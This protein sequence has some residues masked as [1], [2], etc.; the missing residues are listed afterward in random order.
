MTL[1]PRLTLTGPV[2]A[3]FLACLLAHTPANAESA[4]REVAGPLP[5]VH[6]SDRDWS[7]PPLFTDP[8][9][10][11]F[12]GVHGLKVGSEFFFYV[13][14]GV[15][16]TNGP[17]LD[18]GDECPKEDI[19]LFAVPYTHKGL[20]GNDG[21]AYRGVITPC[22]NFHYTGGTFFDDP[23]VAG[24]TYQG[25]TLGRYVTTAAKTVDG[26]LWREVVVGTSVNGQTW[27]W[28]TLLTVSASLNLA[29]IDGLRIQPKPGAPGV[30]FGV[31]SFAPGSSP[32]GI[33]TGKVEV[34]WNTRMVRI[35]QNAATNTWFTVPFGGQITTMPAEVWDHRTDDFALVG[36][37]YQLWGETKVP[38]SGV[39]PCG[40]APPGGGPWPPTVYVNNTAGPHGNQISYRTMDAS[41]N[42][43]PVKPLTSVVRASP[44]D[45]VRTMGFPFRLDDMNGKQLLYSSSTDLTICNLVV[46]NLRSIG[47]VVTVLEDVP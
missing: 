12:Y 9:A 47:V 16:T 36:G 13:G 38:R 27:Q 40:A 30:W 45:Y 2:A 18:P 44:S 31:F 7:P 1:R 19:M 15:Y 39:H 41:F 4:K 24:L 23:T 35:L 10:A 22:D 46:T 42:L 17:N 14:G 26:A 32:D 5:I 6:P 34:N 43:G 29:M 33:V 3:L 8:R 25:M 37:Q 21:M 11:R 28:Q 20:R